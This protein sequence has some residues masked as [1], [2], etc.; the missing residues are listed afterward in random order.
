MTANHS[1]GKAAAS[2][3][4]LPPYL[5]VS[6]PMFWHP[7]RLVALYLL[8]SAILVGSGYWAYHA[9]SGHLYAR[10]ADALRAIGDA[11]ATQVE[12]W[13]QGRRWD[14]RAVSGT[15]TFRSQVMRWFEGD[16]AAH[17]PLEERLSTLRLDDHYAGVELLDANGLPRLTLGS[18]MHPPEE[19]APDCLAS[20]RQAVEP[21][22]IDLH[23]DPVAGRIHF[24]YILPLRP[25]VD[26]GPEV[27]PMAYLRLTVDPQRRLYPLIQSWPTP[28][29]SAETLLVRREGD[30]VRFLNE[31]RHQKNTALRLYLPVAQGSLLATEALSDNPGV[32]S[33]PDYRG[34]PVL[35]YVRTVPGT[36]WRLVTKIDKAEIFDDLNRIAWLLSGSTAVLLGFLGFILWSWSR[37]QALRAH[38]ELERGLAQIAQ[39]MPG[40]IHAFALRADG[41]MCYPYASPAVE[42]LY[43]FSATELARD[44]APVFARIH[45]DDVARLKHTISESAAQGSIWHEAFRYRH[46]DGAERWIEGRSIPKRQPDGMTIWYGSLHDVTQMMAN[47]EALRRRNEELEALMDAVPMGIFVAHDPACHHITG[48]TAAN[49]LFTVPGGTNLSP[50]AADSTSPPRF[51]VFDAAGREL[52]PDELPMQQ[53]AT[54]GQSV[55]AGALRIDF[56]SG[57]TRWLM[58][59]AVP[60][61]DT[62]GAVRGAIGAFIDITAEKVTEVAL[63]HTRN[64]LTDAQKIA[65]LGSFEYLPSTQSTVWSEEEYR[66]YG[67]DPAEPSPAYPDLLAKHIHPDDAAAL[68]ETFM[69]ALQSGSTFE[70]EHRIVRSDGSVRWVYDCAHPFLDPEGRL[71]RY[72]GVTLDITERKAA[73]ARLEADAER[74]ALLL[75]IAAGLLQE[76]SDKAAMAGRIFKQAG[77]LLD[78]DIGLNYRLS[79]GDGSLTL[80]AGYGI[81]AEPAGPL[82]T[83]AVG[84][85]FSCTVAATGQPKILDVLRI[86]NDPQ[87]ALVQRASIRAYACYPLIGFDNRVM[88]T[89]ALCST[90]RDAFMPEEVDFMQ[91]LSYLLSLAWE[92]CRAEEEIRRLNSDLEERVKTRT[93]AL[94]E[95]NQELQRFAYVASHDLQTPLRAIASFTQLLQMHTQGQ[96]DAQAQE[97]LQ[98]VTDNAKRMHGLVNDLL[99]Y[100]RLDAQGQPHEATDLRA[101]VEELLNQ[102]RPTL[103]TRGAEVICFPLPTLVV[104]RALFGQMLQN[105]IENGL[106]Y[107][108]SPKPQVFISARQEGKAWIF[109]VRDNGIGIDVKYHEQVFLPFKRLHA[110]HDYPGSGVGLAICRRIIELHGGRLWLESA[111]GQGSTFYFSLPASGEEPS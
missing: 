109:A 97:Y 28:S 3:D 69:A 77:A 110:Y 47:E 50:S 94:L 64:M 51:Q 79:A 85:S 23:T 38:L 63:A 81:P 40:V 5:P 80:V 20:L 31:L 106:K 102:L 45:P 43:G 42:A 44:A 70:L 75:D 76:K 60:L 90:Q 93:V 98:H 83:L 48:N 111:E 6:P 37:Q 46:P 99:A 19:M 100:A 27:A 14:V 88:G 18:I 54:L 4:G 86:A 24:S 8:L 35:A 71:G 78:A 32:V 68:H 92:R 61:F 66:I 10:Q 17:L 82:E 89:L 15:P 58:G 36:P 7:G 29:P 84:E 9:L 73:S 62:G 21:Q 101:L 16:A 108:E 55:P 33:G 13:L 34:I 74:Q 104:D 25:Q 72:V 22:L 107:N 26:D 103:L 56:T 1:A 49:V 57:E 30:K 91:T 53:A 65:H 52:A 95:S 41:T 11:K 2:E 96:L 67:L 59:S 105:L 39:F 87:G 12:E